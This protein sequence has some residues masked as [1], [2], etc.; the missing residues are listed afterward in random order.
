MYLRTTAALH[1]PNRP[2]TMY[3]EGGEVMFYRCMSVTP[4]SPF[5]GYLSTEPR[6]VPGQNGGTLPIP[7]KGYAVAS[8]PL[9]GRVSCSDKVFLNDF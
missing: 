2:R 4:G 9:A 3:R 1:G 7:G 6:G 5:R 8:T